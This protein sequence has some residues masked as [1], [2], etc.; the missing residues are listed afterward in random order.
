RTQRIISPTI[1]N[2]REA[3]LLMAKMKD[4]HG[5]QIK[6]AVGLSHDILIAMTARAIGA[7]VLTANRDDFEMIQD[8]SSF[9]L[10]VI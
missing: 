2:Y 6:K 8:L 4:R 9:H 3:G 5:F 7:T 1:E 10:Q